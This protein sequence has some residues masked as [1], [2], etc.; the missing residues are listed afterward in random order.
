MTSGDPTELPASGR[1]RW[2]AHEWILL[3][4]VTAIAALV[5]GWIAIGANVTGWFSD[6]VDYLVLADFFRQS[7]AGEAAVYSSQLFRET[8]FPPMFPALLAIFGAGTFNTVNAFWVTSA[9]AVAAVALTWLWVRRATGSPLAAT[10]VA[11]LLAL[12]PEMFLWCLYPVSEPLLLAMLAL[13]FALATTRAPGASRVLVI[14]LLAGLVPLA[15]VAAVALTAAVALWTMR[16]RGIALRTRALSLVAL[17][18]P[19]GAW[20]AYRKLV[21]QA[22]SYADSLTR[23]SLVAEFGGWGAFLSGQPLRMLQGYAGLWDPDTGIAAQ[24]VA[25]AVLAAAA[26]GW[27][28]RV[29]RNELDAW[30][31]VAYLG[32]VFVWPYP[33]EMSRLL[34]VTLPVVLV[35]AID[36]LAVLPGRTRPDARARV[37][38]AA[39]ALAATIGLVSAPA[40]RQFARRAMLPTS[41]ELE[42]HKR[43]RA[44]FIVSDD[45]WALK[46]NELSARI[47]AA[48]KEMPANVPRGECVYAV[49][50]AIVW[51]YGRV[52]A[53]PYPPIGV[54]TP[55]AAQQALAGCNYYFVAYVTS[56]QK[57]SPYL[58]PLREIEPWSEPVFASWFEF[59]GV[60]N[61]AVALM[62]RSEA[63]DDAGV[64]ERGQ[65]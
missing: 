23:T 6:S 22:E 31:L 53:R 45:E 52:D 26:A 12:C 20:V 55:T 10:S 36:V 11:L 41:A 3:A 27:W 42:Q 13:A 64:R 65:R 16:L 4:L 5:Y 61:L 46:L 25:G 1:P 62:V 24:V 56:P 9:T 47:I 38:I 40:A 29:R 43:A 2:R 30:F 28:R 35:A 19:L 49:M 50:P 44:Y 37:A 17:V 39:L 15:R 18:V 59:R 21:P 51:L 48:V 57:R 33:A 60:R 14:A 32:I 8:R 58:Y 7:Y 34:V 54:S 63:S